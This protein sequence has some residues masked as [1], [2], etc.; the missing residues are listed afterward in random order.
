MQGKSKEE[1]M[2]EL[3]ASGKTEAEALILAPH[4]VIPGNRP[5]NTLFFDKSNPRIIGAL[6][7]LYEHKVCAQGILWNIN[8]FDQWGVELGKQLGNQVL[9][10][11]L[12]D[13]AVNHHDSSTS[14]LI[15][16]FRS[17]KQ[18]L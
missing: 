1:A 8:S 3:M 9:E 11:L 5:S 7:A 15:N 4:K 12:G 13:S 16:A 17:Q 2:A 6:I 18:K 14:G 10:D